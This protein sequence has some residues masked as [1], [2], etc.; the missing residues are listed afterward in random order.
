LSGLL[1]LL[2]ERSPPAISRPLT[3]SPVWH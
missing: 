1:L 3:W 2:V